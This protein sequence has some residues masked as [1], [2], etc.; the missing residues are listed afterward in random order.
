MTA[1]V[2][3]VL[4]C[5]IAGAIID[6]I[7]YWVAAAGPVGE[8]WSFRGNGALVVPIGIGPAV[9]AGGWSTLVLMHR[10]VAR[11]ATW[12]IGAA[13]IGA[14]PAALSVAA[15]VVLGRSAQAVSDVL[16]VPALAWPVLSVVLAALWP[17]A[18]TSVRGRR[19]L[20]TLVLVALCTMAVAVGFALAG[21]VVVPGAS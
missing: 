2:F 21:S 8:G 18:P 17:V 9:L 15:L 10:R 16:T 11:P 6:L 14:V 3:V 5:A 19:L 7:T 12:G 1:P 4:L 20:A 13:L